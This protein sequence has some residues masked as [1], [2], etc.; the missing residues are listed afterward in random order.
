MV[1]VSVPVKGTGG[2]ACFDRLADPKIDVLRGA[3]LVEGVEGSCDGSSVEWTREG[4]HRADHAA[5]DIGAGRCDDSGG[6]GRGIESVIDRRDPILLEG[7]GR[8]AR[9]V[10]C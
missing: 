10:T 6:K 7:P 5:S 4:A 8:S 2:S 3:D 9:T 1:T